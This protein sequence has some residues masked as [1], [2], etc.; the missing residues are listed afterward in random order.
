MAVKAVESKSKGYHNTRKERDYILSWNL[1][2]IGSALL[3]ESK[4]FNV[5]F[6]VQV[7]YRMR[8]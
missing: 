4:S 6:T 7:K 5:R 2:L 1:N 8:L 3:T